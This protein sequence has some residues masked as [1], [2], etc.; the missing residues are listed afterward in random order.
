MSVTWKGADPQ[1]T[2]I[3]LGES[4]LDDGTGAGFYCLARDT[5]GQFTVPPDVLLALPSSVYGGLGIA[6]FSPAPK[7]IVS[8]P[9]Q[10]VDVLTFSY[11]LQT[12]ATVIHE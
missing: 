5:D 4:Y 1:D 11:Q 8:N 7:S 3:I 2:I 10:G 9:P 6:E 12:E